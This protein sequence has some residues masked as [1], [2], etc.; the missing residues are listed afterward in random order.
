[1]P[2]SQKKV[3]VS[4]VVE[5]MQSIGSV[6]AKSMFGGY[7]IYLDGLMFGLVA[8]SVLYLKSDKETEIEFKTKG[9]E[10]FT[11]NK[12]GKKYKISYYQAPEEA[13]EDGEEMNFWAKKAYGVALKAASK[14]REK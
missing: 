13:L 11:Y 1:M 2:A 8:D 4:Y 12:K 5:L 10:A 9:L 14:K 6:H 3:F 7:G